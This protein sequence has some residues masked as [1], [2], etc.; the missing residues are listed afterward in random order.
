MSTSPETL[1][2]QFKEK[3]EREIALWESRMNLPGW[4]VMAEFKLRRLRRDSEA[5]EAQLV[6]WLAF[7]MRVTPQR[8]RRRLREVLRVG[9]TLPPRVNEHAAG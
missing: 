8:Q 7:A 4:E 1:L 2:R 3:Y 9:V 6:E 5:N